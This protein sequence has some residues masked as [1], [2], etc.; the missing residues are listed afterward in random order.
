MAYRT[1]AI[2]LTIVL[3]TGCRGKQRGGVRASVAEPIVMGVL[4]NAHAGGSLE[5][6]GRC[7]LDHQLPD[8]PRL[9]AP[10]KKVDSPIQ[11]LRE[12]FSEDPEMR[13]TQ[14][15]D[16]TIRMAETDVPQDL[17]D[18]RISH[19]SFKSAYDDTW[20]LPYD[21]RFAVAA[22]LNTPEVQAFMKAHGISQPN[23]F[24]LVNGGG[25][26]PPPP[27]ARI[28]GD[29]Y[30]VTLSQAMDHVLRTFPGLWVYENCS[31]QIGTRV[32]YFKFF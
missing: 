30:N 28:P 29:L 14:E 12:I 19:I 9:H 6:W 4:I 10:G 2:V 26:G 8:F 3:S 25:Q 1:L 13:V 16:G 23:E 11:A 17:L 21:A 15:P 27:D 22:I 32:V 18:V 7:E 20:G 24:I 5:Y 31:S